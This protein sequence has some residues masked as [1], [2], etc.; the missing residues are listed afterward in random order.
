M[1]MKYVIASVLLIT[2]L[3][4]FGQSQLTERNALSLS[5]F[6]LENNPVTF[7]NQLEPKFITGLSYER[8]LSKWSWISTIEYGEN[9]I[10]DNC[11]N[12]ADHYYGIG[13]LKELNFYSGYNFT[14]N[15]YSDSKLKIFT[16]TSA[17]ISLMNYSG[18]FGGGFSGAGTNENRNYMIIGGIQ[19]LGVH[20][21]PIPRIRL[22]A[23]ISCRLGYGWR[24]D[25]WDGGYSST[26]FGNATV[27]QIKVG[28]TF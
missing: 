3:S 23:I 26:I 1:T 24:Q 12:C 10:N 6:K 21:Y 18:S 9:L 14:F 4:V 17:F 2:S 22:S 19:K 25:F 20:Y 15:Q 8:V 13:Q 5:I 11:N 7:H 27:P 16:G 28:F